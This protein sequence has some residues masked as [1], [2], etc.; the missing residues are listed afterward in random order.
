[1]VMKTK[2]LDNPKAMRWIKGIPAFHLGL[3]TLD[4]KTKGV[5]HGIIVKDP[6]KGE[7][8]RPIVAIETKSDKV[9]FGESIAHDGLMETN[10]LH[11]F[12]T[13]ISCLRSWQKSLSVAD[14]KRLIRDR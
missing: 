10:I 2:N 4:E 6:N 8:F 9:C 5:Q 1:M 14:R 11:E 7:I 12:K 3:H 13:P